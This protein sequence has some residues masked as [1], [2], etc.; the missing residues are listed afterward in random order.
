MY[1]SLHLLKPKKTKT[2]KPTTKNKNKKKTLNG[3]EKE[4]EAGR[5]QRSIKR[6]FFFSFFCVCLFVGVLSC[7]FLRSSLLPS[8]IDSVC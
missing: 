5:S 3:K 4:E 6:S 7:F 2:K 8:F 1:S